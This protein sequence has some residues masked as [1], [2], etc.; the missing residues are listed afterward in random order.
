MPVKITH[1]DG[2]TRV[3]LDDAEELSAALTILSSA[4]LHHIEI[5]IPSSA[6]SKQTVSPSF[7]VPATTAPLS[8]PAPFRSIIDP[9]KYL[10]ASIG[11]VYVTERIVEVVA[12]LRDHP[13]G[14]TTRQMVELRYADYL[15]RTISPAHREAETRRLMS[16]FSGPVSKTRAHYAL[17]RKLPRTKIWA[18]SDLGKVAPLEVVV[19]P[20]SYNA[21]NKRFLNYKK[22]L[23]D[24][25]YD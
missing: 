19:K 4:K 17:S 24:G 21:K 6:S 13:E 23:I 11:T 8:V 15:S 14:M 9:H 18:L 20:S 5:E 3:R 1:I 10:V 7:S 25:V 16:S 22:G 2:V 12:M